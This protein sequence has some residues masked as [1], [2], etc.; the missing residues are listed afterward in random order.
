MSAGSAAPVN[1]T[2]YAVIA[3]PDPE[4]SGYSGHNLPSQAGHEAAEAA[5]APT[6]PRA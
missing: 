4:G 5:C 2:S 1:Y 3:R 6:E